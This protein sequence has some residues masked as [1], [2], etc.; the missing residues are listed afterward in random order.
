MLLG[1]LERAIVLVIHLAMTLLVLQAFVRKNSL[2]L[3]LA[4][5]WHTLVDAAAVFSAQTWG[6]YAAEGMI[7]LFSLASLGIVIALRPRRES[8]PPPHTLE[9][10]PRIEIMPPT[11]TAK[12][13]EETQYE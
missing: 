10:H 11:I 7:I 12:E 9:P 5:L 2:W 8:T 13:I 4:I 3:G 6:A 1:A